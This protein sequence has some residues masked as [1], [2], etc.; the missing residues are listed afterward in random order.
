[1]SS[2][3]GFFIE[4]GCEELSFLNWFVVRRSWL[5]RIGDY[6]TYCLP[7]LSNLLLFAW[8]DEIIS[9]S[10]VAP[11]FSPLPGLSVCIILSGVVI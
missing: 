4:L 1:M 11:L 6:N 2:I 3:C 5:E 9:Y 7:P 8:A 10:S